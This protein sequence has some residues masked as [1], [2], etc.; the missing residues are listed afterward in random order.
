MAVGIMP[1]NCVREWLLPLSIGEGRHQFLL[2]D[3]RAYS[4]Y[5]PIN[6][7]SNLIVT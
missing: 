2:T 4:P 7:P 1:R 5:F 3:T 6:I